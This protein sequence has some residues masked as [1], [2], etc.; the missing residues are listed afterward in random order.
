MGERRRFAHVKL[1]HTARVFVLDSK[2]LRIGPVRMIGE[3]GLLIA[4]KRQFAEGS[5]HQFTLLEEGEDIHREITAVARYHLP[6]GA[7]FEFRS[8][9]AEAAI[10]IGVIIGK[11]CC[12][13][14][15]AA[16]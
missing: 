15:S 6:E 12:G 14:R 9:Q 10:E 13:A 7:A 11:Y 16:A 2:G 4:T 1:P 3:G 8:L 5:P